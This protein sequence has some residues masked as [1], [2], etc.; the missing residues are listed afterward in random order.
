[1]TPL[2]YSVYSID[3]SCLCFLIEKGANIYEKDCNG[4]TPVNHAANIN[5]TASLRVL[6]QQEQKLREGHQKELEELNRK[7]QEMEQQTSAKV[8]KLAVQ[9]KDK[10]E[11]AQRLEITAMRLQGKSHDTP[12]KKVLLMEY[13]I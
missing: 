3:T 2:H 13:K 10:T 4:L 7:F 11:Q 8:Q 12:D 1:M 9:L 6:V 5:S